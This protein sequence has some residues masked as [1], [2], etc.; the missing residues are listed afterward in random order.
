[1][2][3]KIYSDGADLKSMIEGAQNPLIQGLTTNPT[4]MKQAG[5]R[6]YRDFARSVLAEI[7]T[8]PI[9][10]EVFS[11]NFSEM[12]RQ[13]LEIASW[14][15]NVYVKIPVMNGEGLPTTE[16]VADLSHQNVKL[17][18]TAV[19]TLPQVFEV[20]QALKGGAPSIVSVFA[21]RIADAGRDPAPLMEAALDICRAAKSPIELLWASSR[22]VFNIVQADK[23]GVDII[24]VTPDLIRKLPSVGK[25]LHAF[26]LETVRMFNRD[27]EASGFTL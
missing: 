14:A 5:I 4:L 11:D 27:A 20:T 19:F 13:A 3:I 21:G 18:V 16:L 12:K 7:K 26:S 22:E 10:F 15:S 24:T 25:D 23:I 9:S 1:M 2:R 6:N 8:K 17:N